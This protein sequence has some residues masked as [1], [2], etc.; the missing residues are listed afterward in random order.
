MDTPRSSWLSWW[1]VYLSHDEVGLND[2][3]V[4]FFC[5]LS[6]VAPVFLQVVRCTSN[7]WQPHHPPPSSALWN[8][9][10][11][12]KQTD[13]FSYWWRSKNTSLLGGDQRMILTD[14]EN[15][16]MTRLSL[17]YQYAASRAFEY[18]IL[19]LSLHHW[20]ISWASYKFHQVF[21]MC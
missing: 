9:T 12:V 2:H 3:V 19:S 16:Y 4:H 1:T 15:I 6:I 10:R 14:E 5:T 21:F 11:S 20:W 8:C 17:G 13:Y 7:R 18:L